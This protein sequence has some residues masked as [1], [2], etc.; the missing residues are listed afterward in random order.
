MGFKNTTEIAVDELKGTDVYYTIRGTFRVDKRTVT[1]DELPVAQYFTVY[2]R[3]V[4]ANLARYQ[5]GSSYNHVDK[6]VELIL[7][8]LQYNG[9]IPTVIYNSW[10][11]EFNALNITDC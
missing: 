3:F 5:A 11:S 8:S 7:T 9:D 4:Y 2:N 10:K 1:V 6:N